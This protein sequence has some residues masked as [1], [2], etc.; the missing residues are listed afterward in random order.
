VKT[1]IYNRTAFPKPYWSNTSSNSIV[2]SLVEKA[3]EDAKAD[4]ET[5][6]QG[7]TIEKTIHEDITYEDV[8]KSQDNLWN[9]LFFT[10]YLKKIKEVLVEETCYLT[11]KIPNREVRYIFRNTIQDWFRE[12]LEQTDLA[13][14]YKAV[15]EADCETFA[16]QVSE[17]LMECI[18]YNDYK[19]EYYHGFLCGLLKGCKGYRVISNRESGTGRYDIVMKYPSARGQ[20][21]IMEL[22]VA[23]TFDDLEAGCDEALRQIEER[24]YDMELKKDGYRNI[25]KY[26][27]CFYKKECM[28]KIQKER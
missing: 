5:L 9:F 26:G 20:A 15:L 4:I 24:Q 8:D 2:R 13:V 25:T 7:G 23:K 10:G 18:S 22:K 11:M 28:V 19:E 1:A 21:V 6:I 3:D 17:Q 16:I 27:V 12:H 14:L